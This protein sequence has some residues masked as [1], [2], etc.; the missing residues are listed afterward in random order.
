[1]L[2][3]DVRAKKPAPM[4]ISDASHS[5]T[6]TPGTNISHPKIV[7]LFSKNS[8]DRPLKVAATKGPTDI[9][10]IKESLTMV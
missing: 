9:A 7:I 5:V 8:S 10:I 1:M 6:R 4:M 2:R 3:T